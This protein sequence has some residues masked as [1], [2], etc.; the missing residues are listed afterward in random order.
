MVVAKTSLAK[1]KLGLQFAERTIR[2]EYRAIAW[3]MFDENA[4]EIEGPI[5]RD[6][7]QRKKFSVRDDGKYALTRWQVV[8]RYDVA[9]MLALQ[10]ATGRTHQIR[11]HCSHIGRPLVGDRA[12]GGGRPQAIGR[13]LKYRGTYI[14]RLLPRQALHART[15]GFEHPRS[16][17][18][19]EFSAPLPDDLEMLVDALRRGNAELP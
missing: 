4:G 15:L 17:E 9:T 3:G 11:V 7:K 14:S 1:T 16:G 19:M 10:L 13:D 6:S 18:L 12:Y 2:R 5:G 8:E